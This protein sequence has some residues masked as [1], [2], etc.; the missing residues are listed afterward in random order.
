MPNLKK[1]LVALLL[2]IASCSV[3]ASDV[4]EP[5][6]P[7]YT[8]QTEQIVYVVADIHG[9]FSE[10]TAGLS[11]LGL[12]DESL[13]WNGGEAVLVSTGDLVDRGPD[14]RKVLDLMMRLQIQASE[15]GGRVHVLLGNHEVMNLVGDLRYVSLAEYAEFADDETAAMRESA[16]A[17]YLQVKAS[18]D[19]PAIRASF[20]E[21][22]PTGYFAHREAY[23]PSGHYG[24]W[25]MSLPFVIQVNKHVFAHGGLSKVLKGKSIAEVNQQLKDNLNHFLDADTRLRSENI[26][27]LLD[28]FKGAKSKLKSQIQTAEIQTFLTHAD[29]LLFSKNSP[30]WY[31]G[32]AICHPFFEN[33]LLA[34]NLNQWSAEQLWVGHTVTADRQVLNRL[35]NQL[36]ML[37]GGMLKSHYNGNPLFGK[38]EAG[39]VTFINGQSGEV[40][41][42][43]TAPN[44]KGSNPH[45]MTDA[46][47]E[48]FLINAKVV[49]KKTTKEGRTK[50]FRVTLERDGKQIKGLFKYKAAKRER[51]IGA[52]SNRGS[53]DRFEHEVAAYK[54]DRMLGIGLVPVTVERF[55]DGS[56]GTLQLWVDD[57]INVLTI[58]KDKIEYDGYCDL[59]SQINLMDSFD[60]LIANDDR[61][62][63]NVMYGKSD[64]QIWFIDHSK[65][66]GRTVKRPPMMK[67]SKVT[68]TPTFKKALE[69]LNREQLMTL[70][71]WLSE[72]QID[73]LWQRRNKMIAGDF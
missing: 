53:P 61:N 60:Y 45:G 28:T 30:T 42:A 18:Q 43:T 23:K 41:L 32:N 72:G 21:G 25:L 13:N 27:T 12:V 14:S 17:S 63:T 8:F 3:H 22:F 49:N 10:F 9:A 16:Y 55:I 47:V 54:L 68:V 66:F 69:G 62:Q 29:S 38:I 26:L 39:S 48:D 36:V 67:E 15:A 7:N 5:I 1:L 57:L 46:E 40:V 56:K 4:I 59:A 20:E 70:R 34:D 64:F 19:S 31:R 50:P 6:E 65:S 71:P 24:E 35:N 73:F 2:A 37:D 58:E 52:K 44:R 11:Q 51:R 33:D